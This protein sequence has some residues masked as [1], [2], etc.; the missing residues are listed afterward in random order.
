MILDTNALSALAEKDPGLIKVVRF[1][2]R[3]AV[4]LIIL[5]EYHYGIK[6]S[7]KKG[8][9]VQWLDVFLRKAEVLSPS[10]E[11]LALTSTLTA[12]DSDLLAAVSGAVIVAPFGR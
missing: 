8:E 2:P 9:L 11:T 4:T 10:L 5:G 12:S 7:R 3:L 6:V 1:A